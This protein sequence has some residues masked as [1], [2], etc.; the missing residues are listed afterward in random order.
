MIE[1]IEQLNEILDYI[2]QNLPRSCDVY[3]IGGCAL[4]MHGL[5]DGT[6]DIDICTNPENTNFL[7]SAMR[8]ADKTW[9]CNIGQ[10]QFLFIKIFLKEHITLE[11]FMN[12]EYKLLEEYKSTTFH[13]NN[14]IVKVPDVKGL[15]LLKD[16][17]LKAL[18][19]ETKKYRKEDDE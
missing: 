4:M 7:V 3:L 5:K 17:Q 16:R 19:R 1:S 18:L 2:G 14:L 6:K 11:L 13:H 10:D 9:T 15:L 12:N 8:N